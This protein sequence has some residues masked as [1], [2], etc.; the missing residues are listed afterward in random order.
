MDIFL[1][2]VYMSLIHIPIIISDD[3]FVLRFVTILATRKRK[4]AFNDI[5]QRV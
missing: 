3:L 2:I 5:P 1:R 4:K